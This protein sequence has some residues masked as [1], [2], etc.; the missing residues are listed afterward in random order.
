MQTNSDPNQREVSPQSSVEMPESAQ[1][2]VS[3]SRR[4]LAG[5]GLGAPVIMS[6]ASRPVMGAQCLSNMMS[7]NLSNPDRGQCVEG[8]SPGGWSQ[9]GGKL[10]GQSDAQTWS[11]VG[12]S[13]QSTVADITRSGLSLPLAVPSSATLSEVLNSSEHPKFDKDSW[14]LAR[15]LVSA[16]LNALA[17]PAYASG[18][19]YI[20]TPKQVIDL[21]TGAIP[22]PQPIPDKTLTLQQ[23]LHYTWGD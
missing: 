5:F 17:Q 12:F 3:S 10:A 14:M 18:S 15:A 20:L 6:L 2:S 16:Y 9:S 23:F 11:N 22:V 1:Q 7:G 8:N 21:S 19:P 4:K 13:L